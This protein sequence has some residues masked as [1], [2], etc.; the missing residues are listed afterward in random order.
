MKKSLV[1]FLMLLLV[2]VLGVSLYLV[3]STNQ[4]LKEGPV[5]ANEPIYPNSY[6]SLSTLESEDPFYADMERELSYLEEIV[7][8]NDDA[9]KKANIMIE[10]I[11]GLYRDTSFYDQ[12]SVEQDL[13]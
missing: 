10:E 11:D 1:V 13:R 3:N 5:K 9:N 2:G 12:E 6:S 4:K 7:A 8:D